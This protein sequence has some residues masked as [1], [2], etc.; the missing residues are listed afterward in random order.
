MQPVW[1]NQ[2]VDI[3]KFLQIPSMYGVWWIIKVAGQ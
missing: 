3:E 2:Y 1:F